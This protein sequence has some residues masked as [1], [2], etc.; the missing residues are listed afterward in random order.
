MSKAIIICDNLVKIYKVA[1]L[2]VVALQGLDLEVLPG[3]MMA[4]V[5]VSGSGKTTLL[6]ILSSLDL[7]IAGKCIVDGHD[8]TRLSQVQRI[9]YE[10]FTVGHVW[11]QS[12]R[13]LLPDLCIQENVELPQVLGGVD[14]ARR[15]RR[16][17]ELLEVVGLAG[18]GKK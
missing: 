11:Q 8:L 5:G 13:N 9:R 3:E 6:N 18:M 17:Q 10:R 4:I 12:G 2:E 14:P 15:T 1:D 16:A 7:P